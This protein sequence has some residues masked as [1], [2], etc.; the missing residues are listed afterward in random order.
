MLLTY[1]ATRPRASFPAASL[2]GF[3]S[4]SSFYSPIFFLTVDRFLPLVIILCYCLLF[5][6]LLL[7]SLLLLL[8]YSSTS[9][10]SDALSRPIKVSLHPF[11]PILPPALLPPHSS[12][13]FAFFILLLHSPLPL[14]SLS[15]HPPLPLHHL[16]F[17]RLPPHP[18]TLP[19]PPPSHPTDRLSPLRRVLH[20]L[21]LVSIRILLYPVSPLSSPLTPHLR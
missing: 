19:L 10:S 4:T 15:P 8:S 5:L 14:L 6:S 12:S 21:F 11:P 2:S 16:T 3:S 1:P 20:R 7:F 9:C 17:V 18:L 13:Y